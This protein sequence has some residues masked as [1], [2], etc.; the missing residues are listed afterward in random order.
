VT[1]RAKNDSRPL[2]F[3]IGLVLSQ[4]SLLGLWAGLGA[5]AWLARLVVVLIGLVCLGVLFCVGGEELAPE[6]VLMI[7]FAGLSV[8]GVLAVCRWFGLRIRRVG[9][10]TSHKIP[11][12][13]S[14][15]QLMLLTLVVA[16]VMALAKWLT[17]HV[18]IDGRT[19]KLFVIPV[20]FV[21][22]GVVAVWGIL[23]TEYPRLGMVAVLLLAQLL[24]PSLKAVLGRGWMDAGYWVVATTTTALVLV[25]SLYIIRRCGFRVTGRPKGELPVEGDKSH[26]EDK[27][28][29]KGKGN[30][31]R[32]KSCHV[33]TDLL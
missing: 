12:Q 4:A 29:K 2:F 33:G 8:A 15:R 6:L 14:I 20:P 28:G 21:V 11:A 18:D 32:E 19:L 13:F 27:C 16:C 10:D 30:S 17:P 5:G 25:I 24:G 31:R 9:V 1:R 23:R 26:K 22:L 7:V 3:V